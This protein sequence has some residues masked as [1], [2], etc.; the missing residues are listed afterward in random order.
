MK[1][2]DPYKTTNKKIMKLI[3]TL[4]AVLCFST[5]FSQ[6]TKVAQLPSSDSQV[7]TITTVFS[8]LVEQMLSISVKTMGKPGIQQVLFHSFFWLP[9]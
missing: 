8:M 5:S 2:H 7:F 1:Q 6:W 4:A 9:V 3:F